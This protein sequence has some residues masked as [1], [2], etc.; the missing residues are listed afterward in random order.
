MYQIIVLTEFI[1]AN[2]EEVIIHNLLEYFTIFRS[3]LIKIVYCV[4]D[5]FFEYVTLL[6]CLL[7]VQRD[8]IILFIFD[9]G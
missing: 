4:F 7:I 1:N 8:L 9:A 3:I 2:L 6:F 5:K